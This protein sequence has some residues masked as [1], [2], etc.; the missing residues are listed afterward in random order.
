MVLQVR[1]VTVKDVPDLTDIHFAATSINHLTQ[2]LY[3]DGDYAELRRFMAHS[4]EKELKAE[5][6]LSSPHRYLVVTDSELDRGQPIAWAH[7][8]FPLS[9]EISEA[10]RPVESSRSPDPTGNDA[11]LE[12][13]TTNEPKTEERAYPKGLNMALQKAFWKEITALRERV[14]K[15]KKHYGTPKSPSPRRIVHEASDQL[16]TS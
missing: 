13:Q 2:L 12:D 15:G 14:L 9:E 11:E 5:S 1:R 4:F 7:W 3:A 16:A 8:Q 6:L 10:Q